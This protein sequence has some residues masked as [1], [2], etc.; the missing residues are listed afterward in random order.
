MLLASVLLLGALLG[1]RHNV[2]VLV[3]AGLTSASIVFAASLASGD[4]TWAILLVTASS[5]VALQLGYLAG[6]WFSRPRA[7][8]A[9]ANL[10]NPHG[11]A[12]T[13]F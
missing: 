3:P 9:E 2:L 8:E 7:V 4:S 12:D 10:A 11:T 5:L 6:A 1:L 13:V